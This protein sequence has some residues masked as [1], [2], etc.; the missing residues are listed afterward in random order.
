MKVSIIGLGAL[1]ILY[2]H[3]LS[4][5]MPPPD[6]RIVADGS[7]IARY[8]QQ[9]IFSNS[10]PCRFTYM[11]PEEPVEPADL[12]IFAVKAPDLPEA[13]SMVR[14]HVGPGTRIISLLNGI[15]SEEIIGSELGTGGLVWCVAQG[16]DAVKSGNRLEYHNMGTL[17]IGDRIS[18]N[19]SENTMWV[20]EFFR[21]MEIPHLVDPAMMRR[22]W[23]KFMLNV[24]VNQA[25]AVLGETYGDIQNEGHPRDLMIRAMREVI[26][27]SE[28]EGTCLTEED[29]QYW[30]EVIRPLNPLGKPSMRQDV[31]AGRPTEVDLFAGTVLELGRKHGLDTPVN[32]W[33]FGELKY[34]GENGKEN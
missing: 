6:L 3:H 21:K 9:G 2:G 17:C 16:M 4:T 31:E 25:V 29:V 10:V 13:I 32:R 20:A 30:L 5:K 33:L 28:K 23:G 24:G 14:G 27:L 8:R 18:G 1:G 34:R 15:T 22:M 19:P 7:R 11:T 26:P 12:L